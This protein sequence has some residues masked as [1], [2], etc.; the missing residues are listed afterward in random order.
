M[1]KASSRPRATAPRTIEIDAARVLGRQRKHF[2]VIDIGSN[3]M[4][5]VVYDDLSRAPFA[6]F[7]EKSLVAL[8]QGIGPDGRLSDEAIARAVAAMRRFD[9]IRRAMGVERVHVLATEATRRAR[10]G[11]DLVDAIRAATDL[12][13]RILSGDEEAR[14]AALGVVSGFFQPNG[15][16]GDLGGGSLEIAEVLGDKVG[17]RRVSMPLGALPVKALMADGYDT[18]KA[19]IDA[20]LGDGLP[21]M[22]T[23]PAF[24]AVGGGWRGLARVHIA[25]TKAPIEVVHGHEAPAGEIRALAKRISRMTPAEVAALPDAPSRRSETL[26]ASALVLSRVLKQL[27]PERVVFSVFGLREGWLYAQLDREEQYRDPLLEGAMAIGLPIARVPAFSAAL[28]RW[29][30]A[31]FPAESQTDRRLRLA[32]CALTDLSWRDH[33]KVRASESFRRLL[34]FPFVGLSHPER[35]FLAVTILARYGG[36]ID[37][38][39]LAVTKGLLGPT[40]LRKAEILGRVLLLG[41]RFSASVPEILDQVRLVIGTDAVRLE[42][43]STERIPD[44]DAVQARLRQLA[45]ACGVAGAEIVE[46]G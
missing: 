3:S 28:A 32:A 34:Q 24:Y 36:S 27:K 41:H 20:I 44:G 22:L 43:A 10:N 30:D 29:T 33:E 21:P 16:V 7:N 5:L 13:P 19:R 42:V 25:E 26:A 46:A 8:G 37:E 9:A 12:E 14:Y 23:E 18:A 38:G 15:L 1:A 31:L 40:E 45:R 39:V 35:A 2:A 17:E 6:L 11:S 4:R